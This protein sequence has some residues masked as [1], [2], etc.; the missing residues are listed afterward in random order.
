MT[1]TPLGNIKT[2][3]FLSTTIILGQALFKID[4]FHRSAW[5]V[6]YVGSCWGRLALPCL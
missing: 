4:G 1:T 3:F 6:Q 2:K 5:S